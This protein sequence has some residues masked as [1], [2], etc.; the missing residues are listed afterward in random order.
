MSPDPDDDLARLRDIAL[1]LP[2]TVEKTSHGAPV[3]FID[4]GKTFAWF[5]HDHHGSGITAVIV[6]VTGIEEHELLV[7]M[8]PDLY[9]RPAYFRADD[10]IA[11]RTDVTDSDWEHIA[12]RV[13]ISWQLVAP[14][15]L[16]EMGGR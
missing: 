2:G 16:L 4:K 7:E 12:D 14:R 3:F 13:A 5:S 10:W 1:A 9:Y 8:N 6:K 11:I 15:R